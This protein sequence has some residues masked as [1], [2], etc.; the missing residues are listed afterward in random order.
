MRTLKDLKVKIFADGADKAGMLRLNDDPLIHGMTTNPTLM[1][2]S[3]IHDYEA[4][5]C[6]ILQHIKEKPVSFEVFSDEFPEMKR[7][8][9]KISRWAPNVYAKI[10]VINTRNESSVPLIRELAQ[11]GVKMN[12]TAILLAEQVRGV[13]AALNPAVPAIVSVFAGR[14][15][16]TGV[17]PLPIIRDC[18]QALAGLPKAELL[19]A[20]VREVLNIFQA[21]DCGCAIVTAPYDVVAKAEKTA[22]ADLAEMSLETVKT[23]AVD[24][25]AAGFKL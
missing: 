3:G 23:F 11:E 7:Q 17:D 9:L 5:A 16:D 14:I 13:A 4:F 22:G 20:S 15:A 12:V 24:A 10:P 1:R 21:D 25:A 19:W 8:A 2:K 18:R 6:D